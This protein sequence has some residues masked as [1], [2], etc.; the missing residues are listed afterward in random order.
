MRVMYVCAYACV[1]MYVC[2]RPVCVRARIYVMYVCNV[3]VH[4]MYVMH[5]M[6]AC[7]HANMHVCSGDVM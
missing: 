3:C 2:M 7:M 4:A 6:Y 5:A 1:C